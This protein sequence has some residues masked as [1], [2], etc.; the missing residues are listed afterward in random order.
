MG[1]PSRLNIVPTLKPHIKKRVNLTEG[2]KDVKHNIQP[3]EGG[4]G[5]RSIGSD[6]DEVGYGEHDKNKAQWL[7]GL[8][9]HTTGL[10]GMN[11]DMKHMQG[12]PYAE[13]DTASVTPY[14]LLKKAVKDTFKDQV[15]RKLDQLKELGKI[16]PEASIYEDVVLQVPGVPEGVTPSQL[17]DAMAE[18][19]LEI[20]NKAE[21]DAR[22]AGAKSGEG[23]AQ[24]GDQSPASPPMGGA[25]AVPPAGE[26]PPAGGQTDP[27]LDAALGDLEGLLG[28][29]PPVPKA[30]SAVH[31]SRERFVPSGETDI[32]HQKRKMVEQLSKDE[33]E[34]TEFHKTQVEPNKETKPYLQTGNGND[35]PEGAFAGDAM[36]S[37]VFFWQA[38]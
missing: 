2:L 33:E 25:P 29:T 36:K 22:A 18:Q 35:N 9:D 7:K 15:F 16:P 13:F 19:V 6:T 23:N 37:N 24:P 21:S 27:N 34:E 26:M 28:G 5:E 17:T 14:G 30:A 20:L 4:Y 10:D 1:Q 38:G 3:D 32:R 12:N 8:Q 11:P 31:F